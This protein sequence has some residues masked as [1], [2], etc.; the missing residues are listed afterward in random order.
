ML[1]TLELIFSIIIYTAILSCSSRPK[2]NHDS[3][4][5]KN[6]QTPDSAYKPINDTVKTIDSI[7]IA[8]AEREKAIYTS[9]VFAGLRMGVSKAIYDQAIRNYTKEFGYQIYI[10]DSINTSKLKI[11]SITPSFFRNQLYKI[12]I[13]IPQ[14]DAIYKLPYIFTKKYGISKNNH[15]EY[16]NIIIYLTTKP[17][18]PYNPAAERGYRSSSSSE[19]YYASDRRGSGAPL[20]KE[21][22]Y[23]H[24]VYIDKGIYEL[25]EQEKKKQDSIKKED[26]KRKQQIEYNKAKEQIDNI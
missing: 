22:F 23:T 8:I 9:K 11:G 20:T 19:L 17:N 24:I 21:P 6:T 25:V 18:T 15:W 10:A 16:T 7:S 3:I 12:D 4:I 13:M 1:K 26:I 2:Y 5:N 14:T